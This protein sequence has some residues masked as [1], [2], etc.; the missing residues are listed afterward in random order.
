MPS[1]SWWAPASW[2]LILG[3]SRC[4]RQDPWCTPPRG[5]AGFAL[6]ITPEVPGAR[7]VLDDSAELVRVAISRGLP[8]TV[9]LTVEVAPPAITQAKLESARTLGQPLLASPATVTHRGGQWT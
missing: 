1:G 8:A 9:D 4:P 3:S 2:A 6:A 5:D 7:L